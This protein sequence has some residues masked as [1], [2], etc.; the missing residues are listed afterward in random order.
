MI[1]PIGD[2][3]IVKRLDEDVKSEGGVILPFPNQKSIAIVQSVGKGILNKRTGHFN[4]FNIKDGDLVIFQTH[5]GHT[6]KHNDEGYLFLGMNNILCVYKKEDL[7]DGKM[8]IKINV[9]QSTNNFD[10]GGIMGA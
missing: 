8:N 9:N 4:D 3:I 2:L 10:I 7:V 5:R 1:K 6:I